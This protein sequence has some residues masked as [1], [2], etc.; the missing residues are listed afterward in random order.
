M[1]TEHEIMSLSAETL[2]IQILLVSVIRQLPKADIEA[3]FDEATDSS[4]IIA[5]K[6]GTQDNAL[7]IRKTLEIIEKLR[8]AVLPS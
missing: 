7:H 3:A 6:H 1:N 4:T 8:E 5:M 2:A